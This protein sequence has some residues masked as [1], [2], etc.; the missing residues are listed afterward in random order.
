VAADDDTALVRRQRVSSPPRDDDA[1]V[2]KREGD[3][4]FCGRLGDGGCGI[5]Y[6]VE[7]LDGRRGAMKVLHRELASS[8]SMIERFVRE[9]RAASL[10]G[11]PGIAAVVDFGH[12]KDG[13]PFFVMALLEG[14]TLD[15]V[16]ATIGP[17]APTDVLPTLAPVCEALAAAHE[18]GVVHR[19]VKASNI[20]VGVRAGARFVKLLDFGVAKLI[21]PDATNSLT[22]VGMRLGTPSAMAPE[23]VV[24]GAVDARTDV[25]A[26]GVLT[27]HVLTARH[28]FEHDEP[29]EVERMHLETPPPPPSALV[30]AAAP[31][32]PVVAR[33]MAKRPDQ[34]FPG[35]A[36][37]L[38]AL[39]VAAG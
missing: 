13:R 19:D 38:D 22:T 31:F 18:A 34:R 35:A 21:E 8:P 3:Y 25:Y 12:L 24:G 30:A 20:M 29:V 15:E 11:H 7:H 16:I 36:A 1:L 26:L 32:D 17:L 27:F 37:F 9:A 6:E 10:I 14:K 39:R 2:G 4:L 28:P 23:Q 5:V 33:A